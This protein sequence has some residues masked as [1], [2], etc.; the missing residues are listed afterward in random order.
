[1]RWLRVDAVEPTAGM[2]L[3]GWFASRLEW[4]LEEVRQVGDELAA[5]YRTPA[6]PARRG[7]WPASAPPT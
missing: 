4:E 7:W 2:E 1:M 5:G 3:V 6:G